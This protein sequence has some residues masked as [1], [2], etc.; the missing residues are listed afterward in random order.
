[1][2]TSW[3]RRI[4]QS[5]VQIGLRDQPMESISG[6]HIALRI[7]IPRYQADWNWFSVSSVSEQCR[8]MGIVARLIQGPVP[9]V[10][11]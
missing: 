2:G 9:S 6:F 1:M 3:F 5:F 10:A 4:I 8:Q 11:S 7:S